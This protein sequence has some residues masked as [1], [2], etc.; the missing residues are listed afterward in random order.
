MN[1]LASASG[2]DPTALRS[3]RPLRKAH[4]PVSLRPD[5]ARPV[6]RG[7]DGPALGRAGDLGGDAG[8]AADGGGE[9]SEVRKARRRGKPAALRRQIP[10]CIEGDLGPVDGQRVDAHALGVAR[11]LQI[12]TCFAGK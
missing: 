3:T 10:R 7:I 8:G 2:S 12:E 4:A 9:E 11:R 6:E 5:P 1:W